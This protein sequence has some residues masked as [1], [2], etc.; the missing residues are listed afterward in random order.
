MKNFEERKA[1]VFRRSE[2]RI[3]KRKRNRNRILALFI[4]LCLIVTVWSVTRL[5]SMFSFGTKKSPNEDIVNIYNET[6]E[7]TGAVNSGSRHS[8]VSVDVR[9]TGANAEHHSEFTDTSDVDDVFERIYNILIPYESHRDIV[10]DFDDE[11]TGVMSGNSSEQ[12]KTS[13]NDTKSSSY[14]ITMTTASGYK[15]IFTLTDNKLYDSQLGI[16]INLNNE[17]INALKS[18]LGLTE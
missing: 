2:N 11:S 15:R 3:K 9:G 6:E 17:Q 18:S 13:Q 1:E 16:E 8:F 5:P 4:P 14:I 10:G 7:E 12:N